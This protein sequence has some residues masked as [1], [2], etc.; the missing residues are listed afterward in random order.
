M[1][2]VPVAG[3]F[4]VSENADCSCTGRAQH[5]WLWECGSACHRCFARP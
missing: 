4:I 2:S 3:L 1:L 5:L